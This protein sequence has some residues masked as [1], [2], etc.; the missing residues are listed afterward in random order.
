VTF[1]IFLAKSAAQNLRSL[2]PSDQKKI[3]RKLSL[4]KSDPL[5]G[6]KLKGQLEGRYSLRAWP[7]RII[8]QVKVSQ[9]AV[10]VSAI[11]HRQNAY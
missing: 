4:L 10:Y 5:A 7:Y 8:Y 2:N 3:N 11:V 1:Q 6:K 9:K